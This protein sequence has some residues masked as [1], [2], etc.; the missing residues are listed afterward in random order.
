MS[1]EAL[2]WCRDVRAGGSTRKA[3]LAVLCDRADDNGWTFVG[4]AR[5]A[6]EAETT[7]RSVQRAY[8]DWEAEGRIR[9][10]RRHH[11]DGSRTSDDLQIV[12][13]EWPVEPF[14]LGDMVSGSDGGLGDTVSQPR[15]HG[16]VTYPT[17]RRP[18][19]QLTVSE[20]SGGDA[21]E[22]EADLTP[23]GLRDRLAARIEERN[24]KRPRHA[25]STGWAAKMHEIESALGHNPRRVAE[26]IDAIF[27]D[28]R[29][30]WARRITTPARMLA[31]L[32]AL[33]ADYPPGG[34]AAAAEAAM[35]ARQL[36]A[37]DEGA[38]R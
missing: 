38:G 20:P 17:Q 27:D 35:R 11:A 16:V 6:H 4:Q 22:L 7:V 34:T 3:I 12:F 15:R 1:I 37:L 18:N 9:R 24:G 19:H 36:A 30:Y 21:P 8:T 31:N 26:L 2:N 28:G 10:V 23:L 25:S 29:G 13:S 32:D 14:D 33:V 5:V